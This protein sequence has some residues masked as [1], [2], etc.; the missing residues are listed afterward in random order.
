LI[1]VRKGVVRY[2]YQVLALLEQR[3][4]AKNLAP[5][6]ADVTPPEELAK[7]EM[8]QQ[9]ALI[10]R[11]RGTGRPTKKERRDLEKVYGGLI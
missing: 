3:V 10:Q 11:D 1:E 7:G 4:G 9:S 6:V 2:R 5:Y 8:Q